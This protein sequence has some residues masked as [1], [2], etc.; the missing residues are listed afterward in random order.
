MRQLRHRLGVL[1]LRIGDEVS[2]E[3]LLVAALV[4]GL[5]MLVRELVLLRLLLLVRTR[6]EDGLAVLLMLQPEGYLAL[7][8]DVSSVLAICGILSRIGSRLRVR[9]RN[10]PD[11]GMLIVL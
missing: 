7:R 4:L 8:R 10:R 3:T 9:G 1:L 2:R 6:F 5:L 11:G